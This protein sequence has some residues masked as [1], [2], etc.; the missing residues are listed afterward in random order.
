MSEHL[1]DCKDMYNDFYEE[2]N[3]GHPMF[4][5]YDIKLLNWLIEQVELYEECQADALKLHED[6]KRYREALENIAKATSHNKIWK[7]TAIE[8]LKGNEQ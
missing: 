5:D 1:K 6:N 7:R 2:Y 8:T 3:S 4:T